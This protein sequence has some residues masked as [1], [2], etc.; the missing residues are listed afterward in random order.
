M[1]RHIV[2]DAWKA[3]YRNARCVKLWNK[4]LL[5]VAKSIC[6]AWILLKLICETRPQS[7]FAILSSQWDTSLQLRIHVL[8]LS[9]QCYVKHCVKL[10]ILIL[11]EIGGSVTPYDGFENHGSV[12][13]HGRGY[14]AGLSLLIESHFFPIRHTLSPNPALMWVFFAQANAQS[15]LFKSTTNRNETHMG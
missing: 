13:K 4:L 6:I 9:F 1:I 7:P 15:T 8:T 10:S 12:K 11:K 3:S 5:T 2:C 14:Q